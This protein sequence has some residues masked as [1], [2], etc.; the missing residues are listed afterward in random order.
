MKLF[1]IGDEHVKSVNQLD[2]EQQYRHITTALA[3]NVVVNWNSV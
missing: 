2:I 1:L 3:A